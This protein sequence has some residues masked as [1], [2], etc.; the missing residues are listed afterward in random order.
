MYY[1]ERIYFFYFVIDILVV[2]NTMTWFHMVVVLQD[3]IR[4]SLQT[5]VETN[6]TTASTSGTKIQLHLRNENNNVHVSQMVSLLIRS[7]YVK[8]LTK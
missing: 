8:T 5:Q 6:G 7:V 2:S 4:R 3:I 1:Q